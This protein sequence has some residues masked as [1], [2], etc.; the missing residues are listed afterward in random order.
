MI[1]RPPR[2]T[3]FPYTTLFRSLGAHCL[4]EKPV[5]LCIASAEKI[6]QAVAR[7]GTVF[8]AAMVRRFMPSFVALKKALQEVLI[9]EVQ[10]IEVADGAPFAWIADSTDFFDPANGGV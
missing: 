4:C 6:A 2:S 8:G 1:R 10:R 9:G 7:S 5:A 3:L